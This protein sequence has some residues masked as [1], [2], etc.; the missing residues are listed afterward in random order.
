MHET[1]IG[2][3]HRASRE[4]CHVVACVCVNVYRSKV[5]FNIR[6]NKCNIEMHSK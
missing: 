5:K 4:R 3:G 1:Y 6:N 2:T